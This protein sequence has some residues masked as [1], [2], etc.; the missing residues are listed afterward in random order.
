MLQGLCRDYVPLFP[1]NSPV[2][3]N[4]LYSLIPHESTKIVR[5]PVMGLLGNLSGLAIRF[6]MGFGV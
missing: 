4:L 2:A 1:T 5:Q 6:A 3:L